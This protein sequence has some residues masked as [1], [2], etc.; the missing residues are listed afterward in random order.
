MDATAGVSAPVA[1]FLDEVLAE[2]DANAT[3]K[4]KANE[5]PKGWTP[6]AEFNGDKLTVTSTP[7]FDPDGGAEVN[8]VSQFEARGLQPADWELDGPIQFRFWDA[9]VGGGE[10]R[11]MRYFKA[12]FK[13]KSE[14]L[15][16]DED[17]T[18]LLEEVSGHKLDAPTPGTGPETLIVCISDWQV[19]K[20]DGDGVK[21]T[22][23]RI[24]AAIDA[25]A[26]TIKDTRPSTLLV[27]SLGDT[28]E[29]CQGHY[30]M[31]AF[32]AELNHRDQVKLARRLFV[33]ALTTW[34]PLVPETVVAA[35]GGNHGESQRVDGKS[36]TTFGDN[37]DL[38]IWEMV[39][40]IITE[41]G[42]ADRVGWVIP[43]GSELNST[44]EV[45]GSVVGLA[46]GHQA[47]RGG[48]PQ[49]KL[50]EWWKGQM[51]G[52][53][54]IGDADILLTGHFHHLLVHEP[55]AG[56]THIQVP[57]MDGGSEWFTQTS[58]MVSQPGMVTLELDQGRWNN[59]R[60]H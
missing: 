32:T 56:R 8:W 31:Q 48:S 6:G 13:P 58:G 38:A 37:D 19:G 59:L 5:H 7:T 49:V 43:T 33:K 14:A 55:T 40:E 50:W 57:T 42:Y 29:Q 16:R 41:T 3:R 39:K 20:G 54:P 46:H 34:V 22:T 45:A 17:F 26:Q 47:G 2:S 44:V 24:L 30:P 4:G 21:G 10:V 11:Q 23:D 51:A 53:R 12:T 18:A 35:C 60:V 15:M 27:A 25:V 52:K 9:A 28:I 1:E 36:F